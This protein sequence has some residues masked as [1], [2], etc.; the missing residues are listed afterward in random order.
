MANQH[1]RRRNRELQNDPVVKAQKKRGAKDADEYGYTRG[2]LTGR[3]VHWEP[4][5]SQH[6]RLR[7]R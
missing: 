6:L 5:I 7:N 4:G 2:H 1:N 3:Y